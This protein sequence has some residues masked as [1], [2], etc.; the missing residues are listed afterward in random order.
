MITPDQL[1]AIRA[2]CDD[3]DTLMLWADRAALL[4]ELDWKQREVDQ[5]LAELSRLHAGIAGLR[6]SMPALERCILPG[7]SAHLRDA[8]R[9]TTPENET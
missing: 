4:D 9:L 5:L 1:N 2:R 7:W 8:A 3:A 6:L